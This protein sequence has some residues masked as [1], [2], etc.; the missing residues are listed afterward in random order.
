MPA[1]ASSVPKSVSTHRAW[2]SLTPVALL[3]TS[4]VGL[5]EQGPAV[6]AAVTGLRQWAYTQLLLT[7]E[8]ARRAV[9]FLRGRRDDADGILPSLHL[10]RPRRRK[11]EPIATKPESG[12]RATALAT[13]HAALRA[14]LGREDARRDARSSSPP[15]APHEA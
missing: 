14:P 3:G 10:G 6:V 8:D 13:A 5:S 4:F 2:P 12:E 15:A 11:E 7:Y 1:R 9:T